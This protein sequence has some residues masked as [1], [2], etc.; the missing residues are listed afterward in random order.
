VC[1]CMCMRVCMC[2]YVCVC[3]CVCERVSICAN[4]LDFYPCSSVDKSLGVLVMWK[5]MPTFNL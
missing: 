1:E 2:V 5:A 4:S 3:V